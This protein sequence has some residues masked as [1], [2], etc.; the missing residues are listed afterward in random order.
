MHAAH[1]IKTV[2]HRFSTERGEPIRRSRGRIERN[3]IILTEI[4]KSALDNRFGAQLR[5]GVK[6]PEKKLAGFNP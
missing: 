6:K 2:L 4:V 3:N 5:I 1:Q